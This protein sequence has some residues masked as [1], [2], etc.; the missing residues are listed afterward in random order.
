MI[1]DTINEELNPSKCRSTR[2]MCLWVSEGERESTRSK[3]NNF[4]KNGFIHFVLH[5]LGLLCSCVSIFWQMQPKKL[6]EEMRDKT[7]FMAS[8][9]KIGIWIQRKQWTWE[10]RHTQKKIVWIYGKLFLNFIF[11]YYLHIGFERVL[12]YGGWFCV[13]FFP[14]SYYI[15]AI[16]N[17]AVREFCK[18]SLS[19]DFEELTMSCIPMECG[20]HLL[21]LYASRANS[22]Y[23]I[24]N[25][26]KNKNIHIHR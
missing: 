13:Y 15:T 11:I 20:F 14:I 23:S 10:K 4:H 17:Y 2:Y 16:H 19:L 24:K 5:Q 22:S 9:N 7:V 3:T 6:T 25:V 21:L 18:K 8:T 26:N 12:F 1:V